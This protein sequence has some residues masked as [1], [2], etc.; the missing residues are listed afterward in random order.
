MEQ[1]Q[2]ID[3]KKLEPE[4]Q[5]VVQQL[6]TEYYGKIKR[7]LN[8]LTTLIVHIKEYKKGHKFSI[9]VRAEAP[10]RIFES[11][12]AADWDLARTM[13]KAFKDLER[14]IQ[15]VFHKDKGWKPTNEQDE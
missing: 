10:T 6:S 8:N 14:E 9:H 13:H 12:K 3:L 4:Q 2:F 11:T 7:E 5:A 15:H 1:I